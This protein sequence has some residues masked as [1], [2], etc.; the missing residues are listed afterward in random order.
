MRPYT[1]VP[2]L[3]PDDLDLVPP[4]STE[5][6]DSRLA[7]LRLFWLAD[8]LCCGGALF[9]YDSG[10]IGGVLT[11]ES[12]ARDFR[13]SPTDKT[14]VSSIAVGI[15][16]AGALVGCF[17]VWPVTN[18][19][20]RR[21][22]MM[23]CS[24][25]FC[26][27]VILEVINSHSLALFYAGRVIC[28]LGIGGSATVIPIYMAEMSPKESRASLGSCYQ[29]TYTI[30]ILVS[31]WIDYAVKFMPPSPAQWQIPIALQL[32][33]GALMGLGTSTLPESVRWLLAKGDPVRAHSSLLWIRA[34]NPNSPA[35]SAEF[36]HM[37]LGLEQERTATANFH[38]RE[39]LAGP[40]A[41]RLLLAFSLFLAQQ[42][43]GATAL[44]Y[45]APQFFSLLVGP[46]DS[47]SPLLLTGIFGAIKVLSCL[48]F[49]LFLSDRFGRRPL[50]LSGAAAM[51][52]CML[53][54]AAVLKSYPPAPASSSSQGS[55]AL[56]PA[57]IATIALIYLDITAYNLSWGPLPWPCVSELFPT[58]IREPGVAVGVGAQWMFN[59][60]WSFSTPFIL[61]KIKWATFLLFGGLDLL[62]VGFVWGFVLETR[63]KSLE[64]ISALFEGSSPL[65][66]SR[67]SEGGCEAGR[68]GDGDNGKDGS[69]LHV[70]AGSASS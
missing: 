42:S 11:F 60:V 58:R 18:R 62:I 25:V 48:L 27:G 19:W 52:A 1:Q 13:C 2:Q 61:A 9:G 45:F 69:I 66:S 63:G 55:T 44:A 70:E 65:L 67:G 22:A 64:E 14:R 28:G 35:L 21:L 8:V 59:F 37:R 39:L 41:R 30:G 38:P 31:Y 33:P 15:Q 20:G 5:Q 40:N 23:A 36:S 51:S 17:A 68:G 50:L 57:A 10:V 4:D 47:N 16:Q 46:A 53:A 26:A 32:V 24:A 7:G 34:S 54:T 12:F 29:F 56:T 3:D 49:L 6:T 43:T